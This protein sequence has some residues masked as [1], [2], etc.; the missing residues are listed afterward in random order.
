MVGGQT[1][2]AS[3]LGASLNFA[4]SPP[5][6]KA[7]PG[8]LA[9]LQKIF[10]DDQIAENWGE[11]FSY[12]RDCNSL[13]ILKVRAGDRLYPPEAIVWPE[14]T[15]E[16]SRLAVWAQKEGVPLIP[17]GGG[18][19]VCGGTWAIHG[20]V[21]VDLKRMDQVLELSTRKMEVRAQAGLNGEVFERH[22][23][24]RGLSLGHFPSSIY[25]AT[26][27]GYLAC[28]SA[29]QFSSRYGK[30]EDMV[31][32]MQVVLA[33]G[34]VVEINDVSNR[35]KTLDLKELFL[36]S[37]GTLGLMSEGSF[38][39]HPLPEHQW[40]HGFAFNSL[41]DSLNASRQIMQ[42]GLKPFVMRLY[43]P[44]DTLLA[45]SYRDKSEGEGSWLKNMSE[46]FKSW[47]R[48][49]LKPGM[50]L[51]KEVSLKAALKN[52]VL[53][54]SLGDAFS[55][56]TLMILGFHGAETLTKADAKIAQ[57]ICQQNSAKPLGPGPG[58]HWLK[59]RYS[60]SY[61]LSPLFDE[62]LFADTLET[63]TTWK[64]LIPLYQKMREAMGKRAL[65]LAHFS[66]AYPE[67]CSIYFTL[68][69]YAPD[70]AA[71]QK[72]YQTLWQEALDTCVAAGGT[73]SHHHGVGLLKA[74]HM[75][76]EWGESLAWLKSAKAVLDPK[77]ILNPG[78][79]GLDG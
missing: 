11:R 73:V 68:V 40:I 34:T 64:N 7:R 30:I 50:K 74:G 31:T 8:L 37:E 62:G 56:K 12:A 27:G 45:S 4:Y 54:Q 57:E 43:D 60:V 55:Q 65:V 35:P 28:R 20:G 2:G 66:H 23:N 17:F 5:R 26:V 49:W 24:R 14:N 9:G 72:L 48:D 6:K 32:G 70:E 25:L 79:L 44:L 22:L 39:L 69:A 19:G 21:A 51:L 42:A 47:G 59:H 76:G 16:I 71:S 33:D 67:G 18:S 38:R 36:G 52:P 13:G 46:S 10:R 77:N 41:E 29:G 3:S 61:K 1:K 63:A 53:L 75:Q 58:E 15:A 78:K